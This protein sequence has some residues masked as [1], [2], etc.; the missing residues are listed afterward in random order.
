[1]SHPRAD[2]PP[3]VIADY[4]A[5]G[6]KKTAEDYGTHRVTLRRWLVEHGVAIRGPGKR[7]DRETQGKQAA[8]A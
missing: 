1:M 5:R 6:L 8:P 7:I 4:L 2:Y 3:Q